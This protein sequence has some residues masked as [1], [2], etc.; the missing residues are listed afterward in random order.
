MQFQ[1]AKEFNYEIDLSL[2]TTRIR[3]IYTV[4]GKT[5]D[6]TIVFREGP[7]NYAALKN[8]ILKKILDDTSVSSDFK[9]ETIM[10]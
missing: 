8:S 6:N 10:T 1:P 7:I 5:A 2:K 3:T 9:T 4:K